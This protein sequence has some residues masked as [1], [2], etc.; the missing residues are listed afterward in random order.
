MRDFVSIHHAMNKRWPNV[1]PMS[2]EAL[3]PLKIGLHHD[4]AAA[5][6]APLGGVQPLSKREV[7]KFL[8]SW[9]FKPNYLRAL[10]QRR[11]RIDLD[12]DVVAAIDEKAQTAAALELEHQAEAKILAKN[13]RRE[14]RD[15]RKSAVQLAQEQHA[16]FMTRYKA[17]KAECAAQNIPLPAWAEEV[18]EKLRARKFAKKQRRTARK[19][20]L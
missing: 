3:A 6:I 11:P 5:K 2:G 17:T 19:E 10:V 4:I 1:F 13:R 15:Q 8:H 14:E 9:T 12:G 16:V 20:A 18:S 7:R